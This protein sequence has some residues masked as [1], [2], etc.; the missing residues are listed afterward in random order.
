M[1]N[2]DY[3]LRS[4]QEVRNLARLGQIAT[5]QIANYTAEQIDKIIRNMVRV[6][7]ANAVSLA[8]MAV[9]ETGFGKVEDKTYKNHMAS[10]L[11]YD[12]IKDMK[13]VGIINEDPVNQIIEVADPVGLLMG[14][15]PS[16]NPTSTTIFKSIIAIKSRNAIVFSPHPSAAK[17]TQKAASLMYEAAVEAGAPANIIGCISMPSMPATNELMHSKEVKM[18]I[19][20]GGPGMVKASYSAGKP[21]LGV[22]AGNSP[23]YI[24]RTANVQQA[25]TNIIA[26]KTFDYGTICASEQSIICEECNKDAVIAELKRQGG[27]FMTPEETEKVCKL[28]FKNGHSMNAKFVGRSPFRIA[29]AAGIT[30]PED[31]KVL[32]GPQGGV[33]DGYPLSY[34]KLTTV[35]AFYVV[36]DWHE[37]CDLSI[38]LLQ[39]GIGHTMSLHTEDRNVVLE[40]T[41]K[42]ASRILVNTGSSMGGTGASTGLLPSFT[43]GCG[44]WGGSSVSENVSPLHLINI[45]KVAYGTK[46]CATLA[47]D[48]PTFNH[49]ELAACGQGGCAPA[50]GMTTT[51][52]GRPAPAAPIAP[53]SAP[54][55]GST[56]GYLSPAEYQ[57]SGISY[58]TGCNSCADTAA[59]PAA[60]DQPIDTE[61][62]KDMIN[63]LVSAM[64][65]E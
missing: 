15:V 32:I 33:G 2:M 56:A 22:G 55:C 59:A 38:E 1:E 21:A 60:S 12:A 6:A 30:I 18:I 57:N 3:D 17:C 28:L 24:E 34:E 43:L 8:K 48:D 16:T 42:P 13:T 20:T 41:R 26:S 11:L 23:A 7:E 46:N 50:G 65:G 51:S 47:A 62:L 58:S 40:F 9:E 52:C 14:I 25:V 54:N 10:T 5:E 63:A 27:Y 36:K 31:T 37:A 45:K 61:Q 53:T 35:L 64:K 49:P 29:T 39:N 19:A 44:T 4:V